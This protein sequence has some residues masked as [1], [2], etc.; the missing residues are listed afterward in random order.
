MIIILY[1]NQLKATNQSNMSV[2]IPQFVQSKG[3]GLSFVFDTK[4]LTL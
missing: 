4:K 1:G 2:K 3:S